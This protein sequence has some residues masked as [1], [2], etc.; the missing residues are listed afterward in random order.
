MQYST[1]QCYRASETPLEFNKWFTAH[2][3]RRINDQQNC[4]QQLPHNYN[5]YYNHQYKAKKKNAPPSDRI[6][7]LPVTPTEP[8]TTNYHYA[9]STR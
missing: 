1:V 4:E 6:T 2:M 3:M 9:V 7:I 8:T 5:N